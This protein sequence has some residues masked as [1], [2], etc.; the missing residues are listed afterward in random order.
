MSKFEK[1]S[2]LLAEACPLKGVQ[3]E[4]WDYFINYALKKELERP[5]VINNEVTIDLSD[6]YLIDENPS[7]GEL[8][9]EAGTRKLVLK[10]N[11]KISFSSNAQRVLEHL[12]GTTIV[13]EVLLNEIPKYNGNLILG[14]N[15]HVFGVHLEKPMKIVLSK[16]HRNRKGGI[17]VAN[18]IPEADSIDGDF[19]DEIIDKAVKQSVVDHVEGKD[20]TPY[21]LKKIVEETKGKS[22]QANLALVYNNARIGGQLAKAYQDMKNK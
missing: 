5:L 8:Y 21:L 11:A 1:V 19:L 13:K 12:R 4:S 2:K 22:L 7:D 3:S 6:Y 16:E 14:G 18:P 9:R 15:S 20:V 17:L 10:S